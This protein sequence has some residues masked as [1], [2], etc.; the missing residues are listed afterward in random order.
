MRLGVDVGI[1]G[2]VSAV[3]ANVMDT[4]GTAGLDP[5]GTGTGLDPKLRFG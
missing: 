2:V 4:G 5:G 3:A 1:T